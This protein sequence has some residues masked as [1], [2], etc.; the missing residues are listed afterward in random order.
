MTTVSGDLLLLACGF[1][2]GASTA[3]IVARYLPQRIHLVIHHRRAA[4][5]ADPVDRLEDPADYWKR[6]D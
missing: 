2:V 1:L 5:P 4:A 3:L 6:T